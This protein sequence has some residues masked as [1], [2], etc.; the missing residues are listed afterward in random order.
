M[1]LKI[2]FFSLFAMLL[3]SCSPIMSSLYGLK[4]EKMR[5][6]KDIERY[7]KKNDIPQADLF[8]LSKDYS[9]FLDSL[10]KVAIQK[11]NL[12]VY[13]NCFS[14]LEVKNHYQPLQVSYY[15]N[16][17]ELESFHL[18]CYAG[19]FPN[20]KW[21][22]FDKFV[23][24]TQAPID[25]LLS[26]NNYMRFITRINGDKVNVET[27]DY[28]V[29]VH[30]SIF[31]GRQSKRFIRKVQDNIKLSKNL[32]VKVFYINVDNAFAKKH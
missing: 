23:P 31:M 32:K 8:V 16:S 14:S 3:S 19:G 10:D 27:H 29:F 30:W 9:R 11:G 15:N 24:E 18:N 20:L 12:P 1:K 28:Y 4:K 26:I 17:G 5:T 25:S 7:A 21:D 2:V 13:P 22:F 6:T